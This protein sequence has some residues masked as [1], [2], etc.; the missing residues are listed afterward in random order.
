MGFALYLNPF[1]VS[2]LV[3][4]SS[5]VFCYRVFFS[6]T[7]IVIHE[8]WHNT[9]TFYHE[10]KQFKHLQIPSLSL[11]LKPSLGMC[12]SSPFQ[13]WFTGG[14]KKKKGKKDTS[15]MANTVFISPTFSNSENGK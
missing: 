3:F 8:A 7:E 4:S 1:L 5:E 11:G 12:T 10:I 15:L 13:Y 2:E 9:I 14:K 6:P